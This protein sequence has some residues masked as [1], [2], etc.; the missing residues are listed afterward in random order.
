MAGEPILVVDDNPLNQKLVLATLQVEGYQVRA[1]FDAIEAQAML[2]SWRPRLILMDLQLPGM[3]GL[4]LTRRLKADPATRDIPIVA[5]TAF[6]MKGDDLRAFQAGCDG[7]IAKPIDVR[8]L[9]ALVSSHLV[10]ES[11]GVHS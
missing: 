2:Q 5:I 7:Y 8:A 10:R 11:Q 1:A 4:E 9:P 3:D 6:A